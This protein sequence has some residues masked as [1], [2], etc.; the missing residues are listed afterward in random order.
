MSV[1]AVGVALQAFNPRSEFELAVEKGD[2]LGL[3]A[4]RVG[5]CQAINMQPSSEGIFVA[6]GLI[7]PELVQEASRKKGRERSSDFPGSR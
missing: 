2:V 3:L 7:P 6:A 4:E 1:R 5:W